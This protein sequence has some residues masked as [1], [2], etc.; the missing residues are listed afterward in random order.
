MVRKIKVKKAKGPDF[1]P[2]AALSRVWFDD[3]TLL[4]MAYV[5]IEGRTYELPLDAHEV[6]ALLT[7]AGGADKEP[8]GPEWVGLKTYAPKER[9]LCLVD[10]DG[11]RIARPEGMVTVWLSTSRPKAH[12]DGTPRPW[13]RVELV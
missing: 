10:Q 4:A 1:K 11:G 12:A 5:R 13:P 9:D 8:V 6:R 3:E 7:S 2:Q